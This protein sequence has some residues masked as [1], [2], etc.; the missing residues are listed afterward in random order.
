MKKFYGALIGLL[1]ASS[2]AFGIVVNESLS[3]E[4]QPKKQT[5]KT[6]GQT[7]ERPAARLYRSTI[8]P[9]FLLSAFSRARPEFAKKK[10]DLQ[11]AEEIFSRAMAT[12]NFDERFNLLD[13]VVFDLADEYVQDALEWSQQIPLGEDRKFFTLDLLSRWAKQDVAAALAYAEQIQAAGT[14][15]VAIKE[16]VAVWQRHE[17][18]AA[19]EW[20]SAQPKDT[21]SSQMLH[22]AI[23]SL[24]DSDPERAAGISSTFATP[25]TVY[26]VGQVYSKWANLDPAAAAARADR[27]ADSQTR[28]SAIQAVVSAWA[29][30]DLEGAMDWIGDMPPSDATRQ[31]RMT[32]VFSC[33][34]QDPQAAV[35]LIM[36]TTPP[37]ESA[38]LVQMLLPQWG[39]KDF[40]G[41]MGWAKNLPS[42]QVRDDALG[43][44][45]IQMAYQNPEKALDL[46]TELP[47]EAAR[48][49]VI[50]MAIDTWSLTDPQAAADSLDRLPDSTSRMSALH[51][52]VRNWAAKDPE[53]AAEYVDS[54]SND[55]ERG[56]AAAS[57]VQSLS[58]SQP[59]K[60]AE[61]MA[62]YPEHVDSWVVEDII[63]TW[64]VQNKPLSEINTW[65]ENL[66]ESS[67]QNDAIASFA[68]LTYADDP[69]A[70]LGM[71]SSITD[72]KIRENMIFELADMWMMDNE[73]QA[74]AWIQDADI[75]K[76]I[77]DELTGDYPPEGEYQA[78]VYPED[79]VEGLGEV[80]DVCFCECP[81]P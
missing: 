10:L 38:E 34:T 32:A 14:R 41:A 22:G 55:E 18:E 35:E 39:L 12:T 27:I 5:A 25:E 78:E 53:R 4:F 8:Q 67:L 62:R 81:C 2:F 57:L 52:L 16:V 69:Q 70:A 47:S 51:S 76:N 49:N 72:E 20:I 58:F 71:L 44:L 33:G 15:Q 50:S 66:P 59:D 73:E 75:P 46:A 26:L 30:N 28:S 37:D 48:N 24:A 17:F 29:R 11:Q 64:Q 74:L 3:E 54:L 6:A 9:E 1:A 63:A 42:G 61:L 7:C 65:I 13:K 36:Q 56:Q 23:L 60:A 21:T 45:G 68:D 79:H 40:E 19:F 43:T 80:E 31:T 77:K